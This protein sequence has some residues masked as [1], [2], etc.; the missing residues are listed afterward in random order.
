MMEKYQDCRERVCERHMVI[1]EAFK[2]D[3]SGFKT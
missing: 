2:W 3:S 1:Q